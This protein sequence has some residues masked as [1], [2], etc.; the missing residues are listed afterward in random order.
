MN[1]LK[2]DNQGVVTSRPRRPGDCLEKMVCFKAD[3]QNPQFTAIDQSQSCDRVIVLPEG[4]RDRQYQ[5]VQSKP[6][7]VHGT[8][9]RAGDSY[10]QFL[11]QP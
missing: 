6:R 5:Q 8:I 7:E 11:N 4:C 9:G 2:S 1:P 3:L 10:L